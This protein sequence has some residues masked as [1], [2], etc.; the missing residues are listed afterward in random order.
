MLLC[1]ASS[2]FTSVSFQRSPSSLRGCAADAR[3]SRYV[4]MQFGDKFVDRD[5]GSSFVAD[6]LAATWARAGKG[7]KLW[8]PGDKTH[9][10]L[11]DVQLLFTKWK[12]YPLKLH[13]YD[14]CIVCTQ[15]RLVLGWLSL[16][17]VCQFYPFGEG[18]DPALCDQ[19]GY[20]PGAGPVSLT[21]E[22][23]LPFLS[24]VGVPSVNGGLRHALEICSFGCGIAK[25]PRRVA[26]ATGRSDVASWL[27]QI[28]PISEPLLRPR[29]IKVMLHLN[30]LFGK[31]SFFCLKNLDGPELKIWSFFAVSRRI[32]PSPLANT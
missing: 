25:E 12:L 16:P 30:T 23:S 15:T 29:I 9:D 26:P 32:S 2:S 28:E 27:E 19:T 13:V 1:I 31:S 8:Q 11:L 20:S 21:G 6:E 10:P 14:S 24:G 18:A 7:K 17:F 5:M 3:A 4:R 22:K